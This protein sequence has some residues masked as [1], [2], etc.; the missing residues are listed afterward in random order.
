MPTD[1]VAEAPPLARALLE[2]RRN[3]QLLR[4]T[5]ELT[6]KD[7]GEAMAIQRLVADAVGASV[8]GWKVG[9]TPEEI[10][11]AA[12]LYTGVMQRAG[13]CL[14]I[15]PSKVSGIEV[16]F[17]LRLR[18]D[19]P[20]R[21]GVLYSRDEILD[22]ADAFLAGVEIV[23]SRFPREPRPPFL[24]LL[25]DNISNRAY[26]CGGDAK[27]SRRLDLMKL[28]VSL[29]IDGRSVHEGVGGHASG[30]PLAPVIDYASRP[31]DVFGGLKAGQIVTTGT[32]S[33][34]PFIEGACRIEASIH[35]LGKVA[36]EIAG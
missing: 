13:A 17:A 5:P 10:P 4:F 7:V 31:C 28:R 21:S 11:V 26:V 25:A 12:P 18:R 27:V 1:M 30:D 35:G 2:A 6:P 15:G 22:A 24:A 16:E 19:L 14:R 8:A 34:C 29:A 20:A 36:F 33:G 32:L 23:E 3:A 9:Y